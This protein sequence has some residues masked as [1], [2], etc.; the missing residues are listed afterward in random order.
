MKADFSGYATKAGL[1]CTDG[2]T[3][4]PKAFEH[5]DGMKVPLVWQHIHG[6]V[7]NVLGHAIL[8]ARPDGVY[9]HGY[10]NETSGG[11]TAK[12]M[13]QHEDITAMSIYANALMEKS[14][15]VL[16]GMIREVSL[17]LSG[18][19]PGALIDQVR[20]AHGDGVDPEIL[21]DEAIIYTGLTIEHADPEPE[22]EEEPEEDDDDLEHADENAT[23]K[24]IYD[25][26]TE[27]E[28]QVVH[29]MIGTA[30]ESVASA[31]HSSITT[32]SDTENDAEE[33][34]AHQEG[35]PMNVFETNSKTKPAAAAGGELRHSMTPD[36]VKGI[37]Q[38]AIRGG[39]LRD[40]VSD[41][42]LQHGIT[43][44]DLLFPDAQTLN[45]RPE[46]NKRRTEWVGTVLGETRHSPFSR[47][48]SIVADLT[49]D[50][51]R[52]KG[53][54][55]GTLKKEEWF[56][57]SKRVTSPTTVYKKQ[58]LD[59]DDVVDITDFDVIAWLKQEMRMMLEEE[60]A[61]AIL[62]SDGRDISN[63]DKIKDPIG[64]ADGIGIRSI[65]NDHELYV[66]TL[67]V[68]IDDANSTYDEVIDA[69]MDGMEY[70]KGTG[71]PDFFTTIR[72]LNKFLKAKDT[73]G[74]RLYPTKADVAS[75]LGVNRIVLVEPMNDLTDVVGIIVNLADYNVGTDKGGEVSMFDDFDIDYNKQKY[76]IETR[77]SGALVKVK[78]ALVIRKTAST[79]VLVVPQSPT[80][81][82]ST[83]VVTIPSQTGVVY[84]NG[85]TNATLTAGAQSALAA[86][87]TLSV[88]ATPASGYYLSTNDDN[89]DAWSFKRPSA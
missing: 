10:F 74:R 45:D 18:A 51:A 16:H 2:R 26:M 28:K 24:D 8:E 87:A 67:N 35:T 65:L 5:M 29:Y 13:V 69:V 61:R 83:G 40:A 9:A 70:Y 37:I 7:E 20:L 77:L 72:E 48:K 50:E 42:A 54:V 38:S 12:L 71:T 30:L 80:F 31:E 73:Q 64:A 14:K 21:E 52:A 22:P 36:D 55:K 4:T 44:I 66:T 49:F 47:V 68:N 53:Y 43:N 88:V 33:P 60:V 81:V 57:V 76:L 23:I 79:N 89:V 85:V 19:N 63:E 86:G 39:S 82:S 17:V 1:K 25:G 75:A 41:Y 56:G 11:K 27:E 32:D 34:L 6:K 59:R 78:S 58:A 62:I 84:K 15:Q 46:F 3:I